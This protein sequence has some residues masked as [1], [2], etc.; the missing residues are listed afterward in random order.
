MI[1][2]RERMY[3]ITDAEY[4]AML[5]AQ[6]GLC[7][8]C[9]RPEVAK[10]TRGGMAPLAVDHD[11]RTEVVRGLLCLTCNNGVIGGSREDPLILLEAVRYLARSWASQGGERPE[12][13]T[14]DAMALFI[15][16]AEDQGIPMRA[17]AREYGIVYSPQ[18]Q[19]GKAR[20]LRRAG[21]C[22]A[23]RVHVL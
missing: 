15:A 3:G 5:D 22:S 1:S 20:M 18:A 2:N 21:R 16:D 9:H 23:A 4:Q 13:L 11:H 7:A 12:L 19:R 17:Y 10:G 14:D 6:D 8:I